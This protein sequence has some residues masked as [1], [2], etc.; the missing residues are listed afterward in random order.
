M[1]YFQ[2]ISKLL[3]NSPS[4]GLGTTL[5]GAGD[6]TNG[7]VLPPIDTRD[8]CDLVLSVTTGAPGGTSPSLTVQVDMQDACGNW[9]TAVITTPAITTAKTTV[10]YGG[11]HIGGANAVVLTGRTR[12]SWTVT[13]AG[14]SFPNAQISLIGR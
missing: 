2:P 3:W 5:A 7:G 11:L 13:G 6:S 14:A 4:S 12:I 1:A 9:I 8:V 10:V